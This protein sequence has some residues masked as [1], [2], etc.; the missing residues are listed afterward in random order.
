MIQLHL[1]NLPAGAEMS[2]AT[3]YHQR[4]HQ[5]YEPKKHYRVLDKDGKA[6]YDATASPIMFIR[7]RSGNMFEN[8]S[9]LEITLKTGQSSYTVDYNTRELVE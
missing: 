3:L 4:T 1:I 2:S 6:T 8:W 5:R 9:T 7:L